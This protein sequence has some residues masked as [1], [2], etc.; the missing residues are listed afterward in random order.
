MV[1]GGRLA[2][3]IHQDSVICYANQALAD[4]LGV[5]SPDVLL[6]RVC[7]DVL[8]EPDERDFM[9]SRAAAAVRGKRMPLHPG[10]KYTRPDGERVWLSAN[11]ER[12][13]W[14]GRPAVL[15][16]FFDITDRK[17]V[18]KEL[19]EA[20]LEVKG[21]LA[22]LDTLQE[23]APVGI[24]FLDREMRY[25]RINETLADINGV[26][27]QDH[28]GRTLKEVL[29]ELYPVLEPLYR[30]V[31]ETGEPVVDLELNV[32][33]PN[34]PEVMGDYLCG[35][36][37]VRR[38]DEIIGVGVMVHDI[39]EIKRVERALQLESERKDQFLAMLAH[40]LRNP[41]AP[42]RNALDAIDL[43]EDEAGNVP[44][45]RQLLEMIDSQTDH[46]TRMVDDLL[47][48]SRISRGIVELIRT[49]FDMQ[50]VLREAFSA[51]Q[52]ERAAKG[53]RLRIL[54][55]PQPVFVH[56]DRTRLIQVISN[57]LNNATR[58][59]EPGGVIDAQLDYDNESIELSIRDTGI[60]IDRETL[61][62]IFDLFVQA[63]Q[64][65][66]RSEGG[67]GIGLTL[68]RQLVELHD[69]SVTATSDGP[70]CGSEFVVKLPIIASG[71]HIE[72]CPETEATSETRC[73]NALIIDDNE[74][75]RATMTH[76]LTKLGH[77]VNTA[78]TG[79]EALER[80]VSIKPDIIFVDIGLPEMD[81]YKTAREIRSVEG[82]TEVA[83]IAVSGY[84]VET[85]TPR[86]H[87]AD[88]DESLL[89]PYSK[90]QLLDVMQS[91][92]DKSP[93]RDNQRT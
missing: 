20:Q 19:R 11:G 69:G 1:E 5:H 4:L 22:L 16:F 15:S 24:A 68:V 37:P 35:Y 14:D 66:A 51:T 54:L 44:V 75:V 45:P 30:H 46:L 84:P 80:L 38:D 34:Q 61:P 81:G 43:N 6:G 76:L 85:D 42:I 59:S 36:Y 72:P 23:K 13:D 91:V 64:S 92:T 2:V 25:V 74:A 77:V 7:F 86:A 17:R 28:I 56:A 67:L 87:A 26:L 83:L 90:K 40:E 55:P 12:V 27:Q 53:H 29:P 31:V 89:K 79:Q 47:D 50:D 73:L 32:P 3:A 18:E 52:P 71:A 60:G 8:A 41:L 88:F 33:C 65:L 58:Y 82:L 9:R 10:W 62:H 70:G 78:G 57:L 21:S 63:D 93:T 39:T 49:S 48:V